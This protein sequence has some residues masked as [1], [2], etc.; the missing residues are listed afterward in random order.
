M[1][2]RIFLLVLL[3]PLL[4]LGFLATSPAQ[5]S[6]ECHT[7]SG[8]NSG[9]LL[10][11]GIGLA[12]ALAMGLHSD[13]IPGPLDDNLLLEDAITKTADFDG[14]TFDGGAGYSPGGIGMAVAAVVQVA[15]LDRADENETYLFVLQESADGVT[16]KDIGPA[17]SVTAVGNVSVPGFLS[18]RYVSL[19]LDVG[20]TTPSITYSAHLV[21][22]CH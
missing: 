14:T 2:R 12:A 19:R 13:Y 11:L 17:V 1:K 16:W 21:A 18:E 6:V 20:G 22:P 8:I 4:A 7:A 10:T 3:I 5:A 9:L 15:A